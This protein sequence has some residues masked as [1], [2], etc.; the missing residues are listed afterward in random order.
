MSDHLL[1][2]KGEG[3]MSSTTGL[4]VN[5][6][7]AKRDSGGRMRFLIAIT[8]LTGLL[9]A[10]PAGAVDYAF[11]E[12][13][14]AVDTILSAGALMRTS[15]RDC[16]N[17]GGNG[18]LGNGGC[19]DLDAT[20]LQ[21]SFPGTNGDDGNLNYDQWDVISGTMKATTEIQAT[22]RNF[23]AFVR[24]SAFYDPIVDDVRFRDFENPAL[25]GRAGVGHNAKL[26]DYFVSGSFDVASN[27]LELKFGNQVISWGES[28]F[29]QNGLSQVN[30]ID[31]AAVRK[32]G[33]ELKEFFTP[34]LAA[35]ASMGLPGNFSIDS[36]YQFK[37]DK[38]VP[39][40]AGTFF[41]SADFI[42]R[43]SQPLRGGSVDPQGDGRFNPFILAAGLED[44]TVWRKG[45][46]LAL[47][48]PSV[49]IERANDKTGKDGGEFGFA[50]RYFNAEFNQGTEFGLFYMRL[51]S[52]LPIIELST[53]IPSGA[54]ANFGPLAEAF[55]PG[56]IGSAGSTFAAAG[57]GA[58]ASP[59]PSRNAFDVAQT[60]CNIIGAGFSGGALLA[61]NGIGSANTPF[62]TNSSGVT[63]GGIGDVVAG[64]FNLQQPGG[65]TNC[66]NLSVLIDRNSASL[67]RVVGAVMANTQTFRLDYPKDIDVVGVSLST[68]V[69]GIAVQ[70]EATYR[71]DQPFNYAFNEMGALSNDLDGQ[72]A[73]RTRAPQAGTGQVISARDALVQLYDPTFLVSYQGTAAVAGQT[74]YADYAR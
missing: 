35:R 21:S 58:G 4:K 6:V 66:N 8:G 74:T 65:Y 25:T 37:R 14:G 67:D 33:S 40:P 45:S 34:I 62:V 1:C 3:F 16:I 29:I 54:R 72:T 2:S 68:T 48:Y 63:T 60:L 57:P 5:H 50:L 44:D 64:R 70:A 59:G 22:F 47:N 13:S 69:S 7:A 24:G 20:G 18:G 52:R 73:F 53:A 11:G 23:G 41:S 56:E 30:P 32:P 71:H 55:A 19:Q 27:P 12:V 36:F 31:V 17:I 51:A 9:G 46:T 49:S 10:A 42:G 15:G 39:D 38:I 43:G 28:T 26:L 61:G